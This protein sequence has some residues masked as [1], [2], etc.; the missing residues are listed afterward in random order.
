MLYDGYL[1]DS[2]CSFNLLYISSTAKGA[3]TG[4]RI[5]LM[6]HTFQSVLLI[7]HHIYSDNMFSYQ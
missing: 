3:M 2:S 5:S 7:T 4:S 6:V 1:L